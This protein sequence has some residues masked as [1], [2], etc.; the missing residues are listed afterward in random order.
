MQKE[1]AEHG[2]GDSS[3]ED[4][5]GSKSKSAL[6]PPPSRW[7]VWKHRISLLLGA[8]SLVS[9]FAF[10]LLLPMVLVPA[11][12]TLAGGFSDEPATCVVKKHIFELY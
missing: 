3:D 10:L 12:S 6:P 9:A 11:A 8:A 1:L 2:G 4:G 7:E 5:D